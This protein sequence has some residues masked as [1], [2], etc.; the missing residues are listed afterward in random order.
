MYKQIYVMVFQCSPTSVW[1][2]FSVRLLITDLIIPGV[3]KLW[4]ASQLQVFGQWLRS[5]I[6]IQT[7]LKALEIIK[8]IK[9]SVSHL[10]NFLIFDNFLHF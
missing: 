3:D 1:R 10:N 6:F 8:M 7:I 5:K 9:T 4:L 2:H